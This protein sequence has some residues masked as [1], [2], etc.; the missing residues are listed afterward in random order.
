[1]DYIDLDYIQESDASAKSYIKKY[2]N[3]YDKLEGHNI[4]PLKAELLAVNNLLS[5]LRKS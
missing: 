3:V 4:E 2:D 1:M 5:L